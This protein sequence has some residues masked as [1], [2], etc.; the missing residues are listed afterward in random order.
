ME[1]YIGHW[2]AINKL[3]KTSNTLATLDQILKCTI[4]L[5]QYNPSTFVLVTLEDYDYYYYS[6]QLSTYKTK[7]ALILYN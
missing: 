4:S 5:D 6:F 3:I 2:Y 1:S 7:V